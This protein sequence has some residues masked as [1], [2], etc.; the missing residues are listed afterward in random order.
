[1][2]CRNDTN[3]F[4][5]TSKQMCFEIIREKCYRVLSDFL[6][7]FMSIY[8][9]FFRIIMWIGFMFFSK[10][11]IDVKCCPFDTFWCQESNAYQMLKWYNISMK[12]MFK[13]WLPWVECLP[14]PSDWMLG[15]VG[16]R[17]FVFII[18]SHYFVKLFIIS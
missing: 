8:E 5:Q 10:L 18:F 14:L 17:S 11:L 6:L 13:K 9:T 1:M 15:S 12:A 4:S 16:N 2:N 3:F 7:K